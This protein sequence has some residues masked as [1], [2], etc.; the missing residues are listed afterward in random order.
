ML[1]ESV[2]NMTSRSIPNPNPPVGG[3]PYSRL[4]STH[5][6]SDDGQGAG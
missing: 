2:R 1:A 6:S 4:P 3:K 5:Q